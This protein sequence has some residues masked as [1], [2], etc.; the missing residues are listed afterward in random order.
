MPVEEYRERVKNTKRT[1]ALDAAVKAFLEYGYDRT[2]LVQ[3]AKMAGISTGTLFKHF[4]TKAALFGAIM[5]QLWDADVGFDRMLPPPGDPTKGLTIVGQHY[6]RLLRRPESEPLFR[7]IIAEVPRFPELGSAL[8][9]R[10][11]EPYHKRLRAYLADEITAGTL[12][13]DDVPL[14]VR[15][16]FGMISDLIFW[17]RLLVPSRVVS[18]LE[19]KKVIREAVAT[20]V[21]RYKSVQPAS[22]RL[23][24]SKR[25]KAL[26]GRRSA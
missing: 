10:G 4:P 18:D 24:S 3:I 11:K 6:A 23:Q 13:I 2:T 15:Q 21:A 7:V 12:V 26:T 20:T 19:V 5:E 9:E 22:A 8:F 16:F 14:A 25:P 17:P 1:A